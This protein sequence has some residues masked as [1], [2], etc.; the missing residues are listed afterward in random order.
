MWKEGQKAN[1]WEYEV[2]GGEA[3]KF[4][5]QDG[6]NGMVYFMPSKANQNSS[7]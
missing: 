1:Q 4:T 5:P 2:C 7:H 3:L 6:D